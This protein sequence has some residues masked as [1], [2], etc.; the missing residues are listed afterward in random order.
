MVL[1]FCEQSFLNGIIPCVEKSTFSAHYDAF[2]SKL[3][4]LRKA[5]ALTQRQLASRLRREP[6][7]V[8]RIEQGER[9]VDL[10]EFYWIAKVCNADPEREAASIMRDFKRRDRKK[11][12]RG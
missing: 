1:A 6:S 11:R 7:F 9:R 12:R 8:A 2:R 10:V 3:L 4:A 5:A